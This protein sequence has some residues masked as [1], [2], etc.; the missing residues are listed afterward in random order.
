MATGY[1][2][3][4][5]GPG[6]LGVVVTGVITTEAAQPLD[7]R[8]AVIHAAMDRLL[9]E[10]GPAALILED[11]YTEYRFPR[12]A[13]QMA[14][15]RGVICLAARQ[16]GIEVRTLAPAEVKRAVVGYG[17]AEK[18]QVQQM[19]TLILGLASPPTPFDASD[20]LAIA[21]CHS[22]SLAPAV[23]RAPKPR[24]R[25]ATSWRHYRPEGS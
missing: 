20:A 4:E 5:P 18:Q 17:R 8:I 14:H 9:A 19:V 23:A 11:L 22:H 13:L 6:G 16:R 15:A 21:I 7:A 25:A 12:T 2:L 10:H 1:G 24:S 3:I